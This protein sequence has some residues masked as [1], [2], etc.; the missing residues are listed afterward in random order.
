MTFFFK[1]HGKKNTTN[2][3]E[4]HYTDRNEVQFHASEA[5]EPDLSGE[6]HW[7]LPQTRTYMTLSY[8]P[9]PPAALSLVLWGRHANRLLTQSIA[10]LA[11][12]PQPS[13]RRR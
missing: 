2:N 12:N 9:R 6:N 5:R 13:G 1:Y 11:S 10:L 7:D 8:I 3:Y 4:H